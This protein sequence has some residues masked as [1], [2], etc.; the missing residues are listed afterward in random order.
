MPNTVP[1]YTDFIARFPIFI[2]SSVSQINVQYQI[3]FAARLLCSKTW[4]VWYSDGVLLL[5]AHNLSMWYKTQ[6][7]VDGGL[8]GGGG[9]IS[10]VSGAGLAISFKG[11]DSIEGS[12]SDSWYNQTIYG[13]E[14]LYL[15]SIV[16]S[17]AVL[18]F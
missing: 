4:D 15:K 8:K 16:V 7:S 9:S 10:S 18:S 17:C 2:P 3:D 6:S 11:V 13:Q 5:A 1:S 14:Y 12:K